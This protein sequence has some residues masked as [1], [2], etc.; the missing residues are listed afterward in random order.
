MYYLY[1]FQP[2]GD[3]PD[4]VVISDLPKNEVVVE[5]APDE[6]T[7]CIPVDGYLGSFPCDRPLTHGF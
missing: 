6:L 3:R 1:L 7:E 5:Y 2:S 4:Y